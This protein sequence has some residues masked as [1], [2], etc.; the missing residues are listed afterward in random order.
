M[1]AFTLVEQLCASGKASEALKEDRLVVTDDHVAVVDGATSSGLLNGKPGGIVAAEAVVDVL[2]TLD[3]EA[4]AAAFTAAATAELAR[5]IGAGFDETRMRPTASVVVWSRRRGEIWR[6]GDCHFRL[7]DRQF[8]GEKA[9]DALSYGFRAAVV[10][11]RLKLGLASVAQER[12]IGALEQPFMP[13]VRVQH[14]YLN[15]DSDDPLAYGAID[16]RPVPARFIEV[17]PVGNARQIVLCSDGFLDAPA[18]LAD[19]LAALAQLRA[20]DPLLVETL[21]G[22]R[23]FGRDSDYFDDTT[24]VRIALG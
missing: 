16:G 13:L 21:P 17:T 10:R 9:I 15:F 1:V 7:D 12:A 23:P 20:T 2:R 24:Y 19:G 22:A 3:P 11:G 18:T 4:D 14:A 8:P 5:R 6:I